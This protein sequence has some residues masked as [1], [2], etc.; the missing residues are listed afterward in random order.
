M[1]AELVFTALFDPQQNVMGVVI[2]MLGDL[3]GFG[4]GIVAVVIAA[5]FWLVTI[6]I[7][8]FAVR[9]LISL[10]E[11]VAAGFIIWLIVRLKSR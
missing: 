3:V 5:C 7:S 8:W 10:C 9:P 2:P 11:V 1:S 4:I 6:A